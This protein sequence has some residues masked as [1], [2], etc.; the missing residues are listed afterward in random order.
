V[1]RGGRQKMPYTPVAWAK[2]IESMG[3]GEILLNSVSPN[4]R[5]DK[6]QSLELSGLSPPAFCLHKRCA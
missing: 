4:L 3:A 6:Q 2:E 5:L 1:I